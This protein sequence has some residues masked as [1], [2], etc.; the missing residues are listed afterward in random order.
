[1][2]LTLNAQ[3]IATLLR[4]ICFDRDTPIAILLQLT[5]IAEPPLLVSRIGL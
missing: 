1:M 5:L 3:P 4:K 2:K